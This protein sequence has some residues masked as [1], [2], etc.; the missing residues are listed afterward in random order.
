VCGMRLF[1]LCWSPDHTAGHYHAQLQLANN[2]GRYSHS[3]H[4]DRSVASLNPLETL[5][6]ACVGITCVKEFPGKALCVI[7]MELVGFAVD[8]ETSY[9]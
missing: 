2:R 3:V 5:D 6:E 4:F 8:V 1:D 7:I 9:K